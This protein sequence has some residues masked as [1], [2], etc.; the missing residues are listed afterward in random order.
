MRRK[1]FTLIELLV[2]IAIIAILAAIL[3][4]V[5]A[6]AREKARSAT[7]QSNLKQIGLAF[8]MYR[9][10]YD[11]M[12]IS[13]WEYGSG[14]NVCPH[15]N[16]AH[17]A[18]P[19]VKNYQIFLCPSAPRD[20]RTLY[21]H[22]TR[23]ACLGANFLG[24]TTNPMELGYVYNEG[25]MGVAYRGIAGNQCNSYHGMVTDDCLGNADRGVHDAA[26]EDPAGTIVV[27]DGFASQGGGQ[28]RHPVVVFR[29]TEGSGIPRDQDYAIDPPWLRQ[30][31]VYRI[32]NNGFNALFA[33]LH[34]KWLNRSN[35]GMW[36]RWQDGPNL[37]VAG[38]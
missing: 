4:P 15:F 20:N 28:C 5:F 3:M 38:H 25:F 10:D 26:V 7:C 9:E 23:T 21:C 2:V 30:P 14:W 18:Q 24:N 16:W 36:T 13:A 33:D 32:H 8:G 35:F 1:G 29:I 6:Q 11:G 31:R 34:V 37:G 22:A 17:K 19:Y 27:A 12:Y